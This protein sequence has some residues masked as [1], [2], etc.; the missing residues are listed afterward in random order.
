[1]GKVGGKERKR[2]G[3]KEDGDWRAGKDER[4][5]DSKET[6]FVADRIDNNKLTESVKVGNIDF[7]Q[8]RYT[9][10]ESEYNVYKRKMTTTIGPT[11][12]RGKRA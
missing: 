3:G 4:K 6:Y 7:G 9:K 8:C 10:L 5:R 11:T 1:M 2:G 12:H